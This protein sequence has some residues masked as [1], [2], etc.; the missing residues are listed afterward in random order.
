MSNSRTVLVSGFTK[1][2]KSLIDSPVKP[3]PQ[4][5]KRNF[6]SELAKALNV[7]PTA[8]ELKVTA[9]PVQPEILYEKY[10]P[11]GL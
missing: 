10:G 9:P 5:R 3:K 11:G 7:K 1:H 4:P 8:K 2:H 6:K